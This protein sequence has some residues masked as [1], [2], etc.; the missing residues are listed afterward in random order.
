[1]T[2]I[3]DYD[4]GNVYS[5][6]TAVRNCG[7]APVLTKDPG[8]VIGADR[9]ILPGVGAFGDGMDNLRRLGLVDPILEAIRREKPFLGICVGLQALFAWSEEGGC[10]GLN[11]F[12]GRVRRFSAE[13]LKLPVPH[14][15]WNR[16]HPVEPVHPL[17]QDVPAGSFFYFA[18][19]YYVSPEDAGLTAAT[20]DYGLKFASAVRRGNLV[21]VQYHPEKSGAAGLQFLSN[22]LCL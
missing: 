12:D 21:G 1:M 7:G 5:V 11:V 3:I 19:S 15:G 6:Y 2:V 17:W 14:M 16:V 20:T 4:I 8:Q 18:H 10:A 13:E 9:I 22:F